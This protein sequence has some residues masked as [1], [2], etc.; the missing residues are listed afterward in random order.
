MVDVFFS[1]S[2]ISSSLERMSLVRESPSWSS[3]LEWPKEVVSLFEVGSYS[4]DFV[5]QIFNVVNT[6]LSKWFS[7]DGVWWE[8]DSLSVDFTESSLEDEFSNWF[9]GRISK[10][11]VRLNFSKQVWW[12]FVDSDK[13]SVVDLSKSEQSQDSDD[14]RVEFVNTSDSYDES[15]L[16][17][18]RYV[19]LT[20]KLGL[21]IISDTFLLALI[22]AL[23]AFW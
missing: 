15:E 20:S 11:N 3:K 4:M 5:D 13:S 6:V 17:L 18:S 16:G 12:S 10:S 1:V 2:P 21:N 9:S 14:F 8:R 19:N 22:S 7:N 23:T